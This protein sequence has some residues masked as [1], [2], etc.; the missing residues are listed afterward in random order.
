MLWIPTTR[1][2]D[3]S[4][5]KVKETLLGTNR[6]A[7]YPPSVRLPATC[8][9]PSP[10]INYR[11]LH[12]PLLINLTYGTELPRYI[13]TKCSARGHFPWGS[14]WGSVG[15]CSKMWD[16]S[17][18][19]QVPTILYRNLWSLYLLSS[20]S[21]EPEHRCQ[22]VPGWECHCRSHRYHKSQDSFRLPACINLRL[23]RWWTH[24]SETS[25]RDWADSRP[26]PWG[27]IPVAV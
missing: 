23:A 3:T 22:V 7:S 15:D 21:S 25:L 13:H 24:S 14:T 27:Y 9:S 8:L 26:D 1:S 12:R 10:Y 19:D 16:L 2:L 18:L 6:E 17:V 5:A 20:G 4:P 11:F